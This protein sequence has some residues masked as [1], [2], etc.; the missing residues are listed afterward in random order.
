[1]SQRRALVADDDKVTLSV[2]EENLR[3]LGIE[4]LAAQ[5]G[6]EA[7]KL[8]DA[9]H[10]I[11]LVMCDLNMPIKGGLDVCR[12]VR[13]TE[14]QQHT[15]FVLFTAE[16]TASYAD[17]AE[18]GVDDFLPKPLRRSELLVRVQ[19]LLRIFDLQQHMRESLALVSSEHEQLVKARELFSRIRDLI[20]HDMKNP[21]ASLLTNTRYMLGRM[22]GEDRETMLDVIYASENLHRIVDNMTDI[23]K[24]S[25]KPLVLARARTDVSDM[26]KKWV[27]DSTPLVELNMRKIAVRDSAPSCVAVVDASLF[28]RVL[29]N[30]LDNAMRYAPSGSLVSVGVQPH[31]EGML[32]V[33]M[34]D[35]GGPVPEQTREEM[36]DMSAFVREK[37]VVP[38]ARQGRGLGLVFC[39]LAIEAHGGRIWV[40]NGQAKGNCFCFTL[41]ADSMQAGAQ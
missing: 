29:D 16:E 26:L 24:S 3:S 28:R 11:Q 5:D 18:A 32:L 12:H 9:H 36:F 40:E 33:T 27:T 31:N 13:A 25:E 23:S 19:S 34:H 2:I 30:L 22:Q 15:P 21:L 4:V 35:E 20:V 14:G 17:A 37:N 39:K 41:P 38:G 7:I 1:M 6:A 8:F 10:D